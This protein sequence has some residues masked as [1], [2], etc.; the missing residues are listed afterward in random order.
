MPHP[1]QATF[2]REIEKKSDEGDRVEVQQPDFSNPRSLF[3][4]KFVTNE[5]VVEVDDR[6]EFSNLIVKHKRADYQTCCQGI[7]AIQVDEG[8]NAIALGLPAIC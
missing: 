4:L 5:Q 8:Q 7:G 3:A 1:Q 6:T 2:A